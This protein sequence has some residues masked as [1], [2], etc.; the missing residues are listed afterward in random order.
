[1]ENPMPV[2]SVFRVALS[3]ATS[4]AIVCA[5]CAHAATLDRSDR[6]VIGGTGG[7][8][9]LTVDAPA[10]RLFVTRSD[11]VLV[12]DSRSGQTVGTIPNTEGVHGVA[13]APRL[14]KGY[15]SNGRADSVTEFDLE[16]LAVGRT[17][18]VTG[19]NPDAIV[20]DDASGHV[21]TF[22]GKS[23]DATVLDADSG[24]AL[25]TITL[26][27]KPEFAVSDGHGRIY[28]NDEDHARLDVLDVRRNSIVATWK[29]DNC[30]APTGLALDADHGRLFSVCS[31]GE[32]A[33][34][35]AK[36]GHHVASIPI[37]KGPDGV[38]FDASRQEIFSSNGRDGTVT[39]VKQSDADHYS[40]AAT[41]ETQ[42]SARTSTLDP[43]THRLYLAAAEF[44]AP[45][46]VVGQSPKRP[47][48]KDG[49]FSILVFAPDDTARQNLP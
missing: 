38:V 1:M 40:V 32:M 18:A 24:K 37:G 44:D 14:G 45:S 17:F 26:D 15:T 20:F 42:K 39:V 8:D 9:Y 46:D 12:L 4:I 47:V 33:I 23:H 34:T 3:H 36:T 48:V 41:V 10:H 21:F 35:D 25:A 11:H 27:G 30:E 13:L 31:N 49:T 16:T 28:V 19:H 7:W 43:A 22:N 29:L 2:T 5:A 6:W